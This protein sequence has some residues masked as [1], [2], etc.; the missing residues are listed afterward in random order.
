MIDRLAWEGCLEDEVGL[1]AALRQAGLGEQA[2]TAKAAVLQRLSKVLDQ[3]TPAACGSQPVAFLVPGRIEVLGKHTDYAGGRSLLAATEQGFCVVARP[4]ND[5]LVQVLDAARNE[6]ASF[7]LHPD[8]TPSLGHWSNYPM[9]VA[10]RIARNFPNARRGATIVFQ[11]DLPP[12]AGMSS[13]SAL[14]VAVFLALAEVN[15]VFDED[16]F[17]ANIHGRTDLAG[18][19]G[20]IENGQTFGSLQGDRGVGTFGGSE[21]H[22]AM[23]CARPGQLVQYSYCPVRFEQALAMPEGHTFAVGV[24]GVAAE[25]TGAAMEKYNTASRLAAALVRL[26]QKKTGLADSNLASIFARGDEAVELLRSTLSELE[27][28]G[29]I[30]RTALARRL[31]HFLEE[32]E[33]ILPAAAAMLAQGDLPSFRHWVS[34]SQRAAEDL[35]GNQVPETS[36]LARSA[37]DCGAVAASAFGAGFGGSVWALVPKAEVHTFL[38]AWSTAYHAQFPQS[39]AA[40][41][42]FHTDAGP[43]AIKVA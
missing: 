2:A 12:A 1:G 23:L 33:K 28:T 35:L 5:G 39:Q 15:H 9:T 6:M 13:S 11:S 29:E 19:L 40:S 3:S 24:S 37:L 38:L 25:K 21:D 10:R 32:N 31:Q 34:E 16:A 8:L 41:Q 30:E 17:R 14:M 36:F 18:Y 7:D 43:A 22:T 20:T 42:F 4:R 26:W 27:P